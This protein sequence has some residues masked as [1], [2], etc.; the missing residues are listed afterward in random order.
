MIQPQS[1][2]LH[3]PISCRNTARIDL[4][5]AKH[6][7]KSRMITLHHLTGLL[8]WT[9]WFVQHYVVNATLSGLCEISFD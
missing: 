4:R 7:K 5:K 9:F 8:L 2:R 3:L 1:H 6:R